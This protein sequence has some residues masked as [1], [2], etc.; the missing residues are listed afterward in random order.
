[1]IVFVGF[2][3]FFETILFFLL[4]AYHLAEKFLEIYVFF[5][6][7][8]FTAIWK[9]Y[10]MFPISDATL[11]QFIIYSKRTEGDLIRRFSIGNVP[12][13]FHAYRSCEKLGKIIEVY[14]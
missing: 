11:C 2:S 7:D 12:N 9:F 8:I 10:E 13:K 1:M 5:S 3:F 14:N 6:K 4:M